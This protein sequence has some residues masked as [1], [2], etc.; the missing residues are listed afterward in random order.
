MNRYVVAK[1]IKLRDDKIFYN[2]TI[3]YAN[4]IYIK[5]FTSERL[6]KMLS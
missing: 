1:T 2:D 4:D 5:E 3:K 6:R